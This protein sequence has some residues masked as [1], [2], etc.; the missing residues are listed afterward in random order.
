MLKVA[1]LASLLLILVLPGSVVGC[2]GKDKDEKKDG[3]N[4]KKEESAKKDENASGET[5][6]DKIKANLAKLSDE[7]RA[8]AE[9]QKICPV[10]DGPLGSMGAPY[11]VTLDGGTVVFLCCDGCE[12]TLKGDPE[13]Y[14][15]KLKK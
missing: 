5:K 1:K 9:K 3:D 14:L 11:K 12:E 10:G 2:G 13:K 15:A 7:D 4:T 8:L 6:E